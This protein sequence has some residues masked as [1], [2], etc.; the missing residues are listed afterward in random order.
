MRRE[1]REVKDPGRIREIASRCSCCRL[2]LR[3]G[4]EVYVVPLHFGLLERNGRWSLYFH[5]AREGRKLALIER[6]GRAGFEMDTG[7]CLHES[8]VPCGYSAAFQSIIGTGTVTVVESPEEC[9]E[10]LA[11][12]MRQCTGRETWTFDRRMLESVCVFRLDVETISCKE[13]L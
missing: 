9:R 8:T 13:H 10:G 12:I 2:G 6:Y 1:D 4:D 5:G 7:Y 11:A 3:D